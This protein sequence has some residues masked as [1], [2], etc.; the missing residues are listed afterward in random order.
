VLAGQS[1]EPVGQHH[2]DSRLFP[3]G[4]RGEFARNWRVTELVDDHDPECWVA[5]SALEFESAK[6]GGHA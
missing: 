4:R 5:I 1:S 3:T 2:V 6:S